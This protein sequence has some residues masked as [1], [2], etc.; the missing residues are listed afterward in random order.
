M[1]ALFT[2]IFFT[3]TLL[4]WYACDL[5]CIYKCMLI[6]IIICVILYFLFLT[7]VASSF[8]FPYNVHLAKCETFHLTLLSKV[9]TSHSTLLSSL[10]IV[11]NFSQRSLLFSFRLYIALAH[12]H[13][14]KLSVTLCLQNLGIH[15]LMTKSW[16]RH[17]DSA[18]F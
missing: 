18:V 2:H 13:V 15:Y 8:G 17:S 12:C 11:V 1:L 10:K 3:L 7:N 4:L 6:L 16:H 5:H 9:V 14:L